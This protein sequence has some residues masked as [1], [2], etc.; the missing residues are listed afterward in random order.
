M[1]LFSVCFILIS[2]IATSQE[3]K[4]SELFIELKKHD[5]LFFE[6]GFNQCDTSFLAKMTHDNLIFYHDQGGIQNKREFLISIKD[7]ICPDSAGKPIRKVRQET[8]EVFPLFNNGELY[9]V[10][11][12]GVHDFYIREQ[13]K[14]DRHTSTA[15]FTHV[16]L[17]INGEWILREVLSYNHH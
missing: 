2:G 6:V 3:L 5:S 8:L 9:G 16:Y 12:K 14:F 15:K 11:Q 7:N 10:I 4:V 1:K 13:G 17:L